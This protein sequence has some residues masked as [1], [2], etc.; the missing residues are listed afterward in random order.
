MIR[1]YDNGFSTTVGFEN[2]PGVGI[3]EKDITPPGITAG[4][5]IDTTTMRNTAWRTLTG[6]SLKTFTPITVTV[7]FDFPS[8]NAIQSEIGEN[9]IIVLTFPEGATV[10]FYGWIEEFVPAAFVEGE[11]P[12]AKMTIQPSLSSPA[13]LETPPVYNDIIVELIIGLEY[14]A[15]PLFEDENNIIRVRV[16]NQTLIRDAE[17]LVV[18]VELP[19]SFAYVS[20]DFPATLN[21]TTL[22]ILMGTI[23][24]GSNGQIDVV[25]NPSTSG[26]HIMEASV[27]ATISFIDED[28]STL[29]VEDSFIVFDRALCAVTT[30]DGFVTAGG[31]LFDCYPIGEILDQFDRGDPQI[32]LLGGTGFT[33]NWVVIDSPFVVYGDDFDDYADIDPI[34]TSLAGGTGFASAWRFNS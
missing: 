9:Q 28:N 20:C 25:V 33:G 26:T 27:S 19:P 10:T 30:I 14:T 22:T 18:I 13:G 21:G 23:L 32:P 8:L 11:Q 16:S 7:A 1:R 4:G 34:N 17:G 2:L 3:F 24:A 15:Y 29:T 6:R 5:P 12:T 31:D